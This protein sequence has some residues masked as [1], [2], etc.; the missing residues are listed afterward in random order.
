MATPRRRRAA[1]RPP[2]VSEHVAAGRGEHWPAVVVGAVDDELV[3]AGR[4]ASLFLRQAGG[5]RG[6]GSHWERSQCQQRSKY[7]VV[8]KVPVTAQVDRSRLNILAFW[9]PQVAPFQH[10]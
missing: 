5:M 10:Q 2:D 3:V 7:Q 4:K 9:N 1:R 6:E 8:A